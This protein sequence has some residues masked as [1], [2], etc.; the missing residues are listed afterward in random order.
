MKILDYEL[1]L[2][3]LTVERIEDAYDKAIDECLFG[4]KRAKELTHLLYVATG[5]NITLDEF[6]TKLSEQYTYMQLIDI[7]NKL[8]EGE[9]KNAESVTVDA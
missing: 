2:D 8:I 5:A 7:L 6:K 3:N 1:K 4:K 9:E